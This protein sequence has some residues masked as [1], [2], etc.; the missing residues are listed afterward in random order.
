MAIT[1][2]ISAIGNTSSVYPLILRD[3]GVEIPS[4]VYL[5]YKEN[6]EDK[7]VAFLAT[8][9]RILDE[10][11]TSAVWLGGIPLVEN[12]IDK[13]IIKKNGFNPNVNL[14]LFKESDFQGI[15]FNIKTFEEKLKKGNLDE[16]VANEINAALEDMKKVKLNKGVYEK[17]LSTKF[18]A[19]TAI[20]VAFMGFVIPKCIFALTAKTKAAKKAREEQML[21]NK[22]NFNQFY[23]NNDIFTSMSLK[24]S[25]NTTFTGSFSSTVANFSTYQKMAAIDGGYAVGR[26]TTSRKKNEAVDIAFKMA[27]M[28][29]LN[30]VAPKYIEKILDGVA[31]KV[32]NLDVKLDPLML[33]DKEFLKQ[34]SNKTL[35]LPEKNDGAS[36]LK[37][38]DENPDALFTKYA[39]K[40]E[41]IKLLKCGVRDPRAYVDVNELSKFKKS[42]EEFEGKALSIA[43]KN[44]DALTL[45]KTVQKFAKKAKV[46]KSLNILANVGLSSFL[47][48]YCLPKV[49]YIFREWYTGS[50]LEPGIADEPVTKSL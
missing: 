27:G 2:I 35:K 28:M 6:E 23:K 4:K 12:F 1:N 40:F 39:A 36:L 50:K 42:I 7:D 45:E 31:N 22:N 47:L 30:F 26:V 10:Y 5:T 41:K 19:A 8:R 46:V 24:K 33:A 25:K 13:F 29:F 49:Q 32:L 37:F 15:D 21:K 3:C 18:I 34:I 38:V 44:T 48:A 14:K 17:L 9:E 20:P 43:G 11:A 16:K